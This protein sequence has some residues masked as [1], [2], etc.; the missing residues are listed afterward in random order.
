MKTHA[1]MELTK[2]ARVQEQGQRKSMASQAWWMGLWPQHSEAEERNMQLKAS[3]GYRE[4]HCVILNISDVGRRKVD[5]NR[6]YKMH[7]SNK[8]ENT[9]KLKQQ[10]KMALH[11]HSW[12]E[13]E[14][15]GYDATAEWTALHS[16]L[17]SSN[18]WQ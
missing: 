2:L 17:R 13:L 6:S 7:L 3:L 5:L 15:L 4:K 10:G 14:R 11:A 18:K 16:I 1:G 12:A 8:K 9:V